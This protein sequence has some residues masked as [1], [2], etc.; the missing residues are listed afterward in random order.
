MSSLSRRWI[1]IGA[2]LGAL[3]VSFGAFGAHMLRDYLSDLGYTGE[4][5][6]RRLEIFATAI[7]YQ[8]V[9]A[10]A[11]VFTGLALNSRAAASWNVAAWLFLVGIVLFSGALKILT[12]ASASWSWLGAVA[13]I[14][15][16][17]MIVGW[18]VLAVGALRKQIE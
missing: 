5:L 12:F 17:S 13:P 6:T 1:A 8:L 14:G 2:L 15:G 11:L 18:V 3:G 7:D 16:I 10:L 4:D 9:H